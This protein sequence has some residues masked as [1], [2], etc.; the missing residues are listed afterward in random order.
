MAGFIITCVH[1]ILTWPKSSPW[2]RRPYSKC[3]LSRGGDPPAKVFSLPVGVKSPLH[4]FTPFPPGTPYPT[5]P[6]IPGRRP[7]DCFLDCP[8]LTLWQLRAFQCLLGVLYGVFLLKTPPYNDLI[9]P[10]NQAPYVPQNHVFPRRGNY[11][12]E[13]SPKPWF[14]DFAK[15][16]FG[17][18]QLTLHPPTP[19]YTPSPWIPLSPHIPT[20]PY[21]G[22]VL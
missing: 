19:L 11:T 10:S 1:H 16:R 4:P 17:E 18:S 8:L 6:Y 15:S 21:I 13:V 3:K 5:Y 9:T 12:F 22:G 7:I 2:F 20:S 14:E